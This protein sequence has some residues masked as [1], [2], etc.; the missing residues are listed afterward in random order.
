MSKIERAEVLVTSPGRIFDTSRIATSDGVT[1]LG[2]EYDDETAA[3]F[4][5]QPSTFP[6][7]A[8]STAP[9]TTGERAVISRPAHRQRRHR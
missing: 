1:G 3:R 5:Y 2:D 6:S 8:V 7:R 4:P 9:S